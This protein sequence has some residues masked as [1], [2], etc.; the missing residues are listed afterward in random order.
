MRDHEVRVQRPGERFPARSS[1]PGSWP[2][3]PPTGAGRGRGGRDGRL[4][5]G[6]QR[7][8]GR[9]PPWTAPRWPRPGPWP[10]PTPGP[11][12]RLSSACPETR[13]QA[14]WAAWANGTAV[15]EL[16]FHDTFLAADYA[17]PGDNIPPLL[18]VAQQCGRTGGRPRRGDRR[19]LRGPGRPGQGICLHEHKND[20]VAHLG[21]ATAA[22]LGTL[23]GLPVEVT[24]QAVNQAL[25]VATATRQSRKGQISSWKA[26]A[27]AHAGK[28]AVEAVDRAMR[29]EGAPAPIY[30]GD[31][32]VIAWLLGGPEAELPGAAARAG[33]APPGDPGHLHQGPLRR[34]PGPGPHR[35]G[36]RLRPAGRRPR[37]GRAGSCSAPAT[38]PTT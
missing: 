12:G 22:G 10:W 1:W 18:A 38:T 24:Y 7:G 8:R 36:L 20:H 37:P 34:V 25:H 19:G 16:D 15:R 21:P 33:R 14:E 5:A 3:W 6:G 31:D 26:Y 30:E 4:P 28:L 29:G 23:L 11:A 27:P 32:G 35:P 17:H 9:W 13:V 2:R